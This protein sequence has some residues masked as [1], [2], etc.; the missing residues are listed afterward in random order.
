MGHLLGSN[1]DKKVTAVIF[2]SK[3]H[4]LNLQGTTR[5]N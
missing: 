2:L 5:Q 3:M 1:E 4:N